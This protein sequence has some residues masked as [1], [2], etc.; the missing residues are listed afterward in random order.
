M[1]RVAGV[2]LNQYLGRP[3]GAFAELAT[4]VESLI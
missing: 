2:W 3:T 1:A 4:N